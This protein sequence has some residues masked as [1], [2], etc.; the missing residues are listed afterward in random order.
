MLEFS[1][2]GHTATRKSPFAGRL[3]RNAGSSGSVGLRRVPPPRSEVAGAETGSPLTGV[4]LDLTALGGAGCTQLLLHPVFHKLESMLGSHE[5]ICM[6]NVQFHI[7]MKVCSA[8][9]QYHI[10]LK[11]CAAKRAV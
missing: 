9:V 6:A 2:C 7:N 5:E 1:F 3:R 4:S 8:N 11:M 10:N